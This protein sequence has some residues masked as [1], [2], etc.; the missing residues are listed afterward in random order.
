MGTTITTKEHVYFNLSQNFAAG[1]TF[2]LQEVYDLCLKH[3]RVDE[4]YDDITDEEA[5]IR[6]ALQRLESDDLVKFYCRDSNDLTG[7]YCL[8]ETKDQINP[9]QNIFDLAELKKHG[10]WYEKSPGV[11][12]DRWAILHKDEVMSHSVARI[13]KIECQT[14]VGEALFQTTINQITEEV[15]DGDYDYRCY[16]PAV[17]ELDEPIHYTD[18]NGKKYV[19][20]YIVRDG[21]N[22]YELPWRY[23]PCCVISGEDEYSLLQYGAIANAPTREKKNDCTPD[24]V[25]YM[26][27]LGFEHKKIEKNLDAVID[28]LKTRYKEVRK[29]DR[30][31]FAADILAEEGIKASIEPYD[32]S[33]GQKIL[34]DVFKKEGV[35]GERINLMNEDD[36]SFVIGWGRKPDHYRK[37]FLIF[38]KQLQYPENYYTAYSFL[39]QGQGV[40]T[41]P[42]EKNID[43]LRILMEGERKRILKHYR[44]VLKA[45]DEGTLKPIHYKWLPQANNIEDHDVLY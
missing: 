36:T 8:L 32:I 18:E 39:E 17:S 9:N 27:Q 31:I 23:F 16:Q 44:E 3:N 35:K 5:T 20:K 2:T 45:E 15:A 26:I 41:E 4:L 24:D 43:E 33:K 11:T 28:V 13:L 12:F 10:R 21:N 25:K 14:R 22:R 37:Y 19:F 38:E 42:T 1:V 30:R 34:K 40:T 6:A 7:T 29:K